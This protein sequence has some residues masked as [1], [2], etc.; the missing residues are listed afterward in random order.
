MKKK[1]IID[2][3]VV[4]VA[5]W[6]KGEYGDIARHFIKRAENKEFQLVTL[7]YMLEQIVKWNHLQLRERI[8]EFYLKESS[9]MITNEDID[10][11]IE[12][13]GFNDGKLLKELQDIK[14]KDEDA[15]IVMVASIFEV[16]YLI[17]I[18]L[19]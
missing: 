17:L 13:I 1:I 4:T 6:D 3:D 12:D 7:F 16:D 8:E 11:K 10:D 5:K 9:I 2:L 18:N 15:F 14:I 19:Q